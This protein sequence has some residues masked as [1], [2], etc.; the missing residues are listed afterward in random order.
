MYTTSSVAQA[1][2]QKKS[3]VAQAAW[4]KYYNSMQFFLIM[5]THI[6]HK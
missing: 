4:A 1:T 5:L 2:Y 6:K 3:S